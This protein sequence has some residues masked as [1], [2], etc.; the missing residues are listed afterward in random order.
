MIW[1]TV[2]SWSCFSWVYRASPSLT[3][4]NI[5]SLLSGIISHCSSPVQLPLFLVFCALVWRLPCR[6]ERSQYWDSKVKWQSNPPGLC[7]RWEVI[8]L[9]C[10]APRELKV[11]REAQRWSQCWGGAPGGG[12]TSPAVSVLLL[13]ARPGAE[14]GPGRPL[15]LPAVESA[16]LNSGLSLETD[17]WE[18]CCL[19]LMT[20]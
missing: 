20:V 11:G 1:A 19:W 8:R 6:L 9:A 10:P 13:R 7:S 2:S 14:W 17:I 16:L 4:K 3:A 12:S 15:C 18:S 5:I